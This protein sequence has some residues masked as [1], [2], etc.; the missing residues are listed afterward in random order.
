MKLHNI[1]IDHEHGLCDIEAPE[2]VYEYDSCVLNGTRRYAKVKYKQPLLNKSGAPVDLI[3]VASQ[4]EHGDVTFTEVR[5]AL[6]SHVSSNFSHCGGVREALK[7][8]I[9]D[10][11]GRRR[12]TFSTRRPNG[13]RRL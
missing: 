10:T 11:E 3:P 6:M 8:A 12:P 1:I 5:D 7:D 4:Q 9:F 2:D 13:R